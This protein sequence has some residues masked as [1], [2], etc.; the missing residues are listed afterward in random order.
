MTIE[1]VRWIA[2]MGLLVM[3]A[4]IVIMIGVLVVE[5]VISIIKDFK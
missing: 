3:E 5:A 1:I 4:V 2:L